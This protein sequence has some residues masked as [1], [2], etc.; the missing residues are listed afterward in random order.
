MTVEPKAV[1]PGPTVDGFTV[2]DA[3]AA[4]DLVVTDGQ[5]RLFKGAKVS[6]KS[7]GRKEPKK[8]AVKS[9][10]N[11]DGALTASADDAGKKVQKK[12]TE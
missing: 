3:L 4:G 2:V 9:E 10:E 1:T 12:A 11:K 5:L 8:A 6:F 7:D